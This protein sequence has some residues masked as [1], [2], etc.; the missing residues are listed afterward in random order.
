MSFR[1]QLA[2]IAFTAGLAVAWGFV[3]TLAR[4]SRTANNPF[5]TPVFGIDTAFDGSL[6]VADAGAGIVRLRHNRGTLI[7]ELP[8]VTDVAPTWFGLFAVTGGTTDP[9]QESPL[10][11]KLFRVAHGRV[12]QLADLAA[13]E[14]TVNPDGG[15][16]ESNPFDVAAL[17]NG[18][19]LVADAAANA[20]L[21][22]DH[23]GNIDWVAT[24]PTELVS[25][26]NA[27]QLVGCPAGPPNICNLPPMIP[28]EAVATS[29]AV[30]PDGAYYV[31]ELKGFPAPTGASRIWRIKPH[32]RHAAC[33]T[34]PDCTVIADGFTS[35]VDLSFGWDGTLHV[36]ELDEASW[37][38]VENQ[39]PTAGTVTACKRQRR[40]GTWTCDVEAAGLFMPMAATVDF[41][42][43]VHVVT[44]AL[45]PG[46]A[47]IITLQ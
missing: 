14:A 4:E 11:R 22:V 33:G 35:I 10:R 21:I 29:I 8:T 44:S 5:A 2:A 15:V 1:K 30:G 41:R 12:T 26:D 24:L 18:S 38:A 31:G 36:V 46:A 47:E 28:A 17:W 40:T 7:A 37:F 20:L 23:R 16:I 25:T 34:S 19:A 42:G 43:R 39:T 32:A 3:P 13:F 45:V 27:K 6:L 9:N